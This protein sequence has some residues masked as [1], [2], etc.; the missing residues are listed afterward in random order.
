MG[1]SILVLLVL[2]VVSVSLILLLLQVVLVDVVTVLSK[3]LMQEIIS[4]SCHL[5][6]HHCCWLFLEA[7]WL[8]Y[9][10]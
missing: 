3:A 7:A 5:C 9:Q 2:I 10:T 8:S 1:Y 4:H 6:L